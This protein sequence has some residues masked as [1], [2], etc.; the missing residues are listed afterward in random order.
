VESRYQQKFLQDG[1]DYSTAALCYVNIIAGAVFSIGF[2]F[3]GTGNR[4]AFK[5]VQQY[6]NF[7]KKLKVIQSNKDSIGMIHTNMTKN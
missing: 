7:F 2:K 4:E 5:L 6:S 3:A 1:I